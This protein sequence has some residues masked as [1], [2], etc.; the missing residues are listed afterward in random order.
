VDEAMKIINKNKPIG[1]CGTLLALAG[2]T[3][4][5]SFLPSI[6]VPT[7]IM[8][9]AHDRI[10]PPAHSESL[11]AAIRDSELH[12]I[13]NAGHFANLENSRQFNEHLL[14]FA[15]NTVRRAD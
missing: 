11:H 3:D 5:T 14:N 2:R 7:S 12:R 1:L 8:V 4:T 9:G 6:N 10:A 15:E 13:A